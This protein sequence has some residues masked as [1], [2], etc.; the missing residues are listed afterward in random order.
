MI[1]AFAENESFCAEKLIPNN[2]IISH[3]IHVRYG[4]GCGGGKTSGAWILN[5]LERFKSELFISD[6][7]LEWQSGISETI[8]LYPVLSGNDNIPEFE[9]I[10]KIQSK[11]WSNNGDV[12]WNLVF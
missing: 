7:K 9:S 1:Y 4:N 2:S 10:R 5:V 11:S 8:R 12:K 3:I 6:G